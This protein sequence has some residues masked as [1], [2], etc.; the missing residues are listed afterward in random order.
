MRYGKPRHATPDKCLALKAFC[1]V[2][3]R[4]GHFEGQYFSKTVATEVDMDSEE[5]TFLGGVRANNNTPWL[6]IIKFHG[7]KVVF[8][9]DIGV[10]VTFISE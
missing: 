7:M 6:T 8:K 2:C 1:Y 10:E 3:K 5:E 4:K 9:M